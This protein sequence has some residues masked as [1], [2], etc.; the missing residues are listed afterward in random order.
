MKRIILLVLVFVVYYGNAVCEEITYVVT[1]DTQLS[2]ENNNL[3][4]TPINEG[5]LVFFQGRTR[6]SKIVASYPDIP[7]T[8][9]ENEILIRTERGD[10]GWIMTSHILLLENQPLS[11]SITD[12]IWIQ[13]YY[14]QFLLEGAEKEKLL[15]YEPF[16]TNI[17]EEFLQDDP[18]LPPW[19]TNV[20]VTNFVI[21][22]N[23]IKINRIYISDSRTFITI[24]QRNEND[25]VKLNVLNLGEMNFVRQAPLN[26]K[27]IEGNT[28]R[29]TLKLDGDY[30]DIIIDDD[31]QAIATLVGVDA[32]FQREVI[33]FFRD[34]TVNLSRITWPRRAEGTMDYPPPIDMSSYRP[35]H[36]VTENLR[37]RDSSNTSSLIVTTLQKDTEVQVIETGTSSTIHNITA[38][39]VLIISSTGFTG[40][41]FSR[42]LEEIAVNNSAADA[43]D[44]TAENSLVSNKDAK[45]LPFWVWIVIGAGVVVGVAVVVIIRK[46]R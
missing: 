42:F 46:R 27:F 22:N 3:L 8:Q 6:S 14:Q 15:Q 10:R 28:Y 38:P 45:V 4:K 29:F 26:R 11:I 25:S 5:I 32:Y 13:S 33:N 36:R 23:I 31:S 40:W 19:W 12:K 24:S 20:A 16:W 1:Q 43:I 30:M 7:I 21:Q 9:Y 39:W 34:E 35:T 2:G 37:L 44:D 41:C 17:Q 18:N